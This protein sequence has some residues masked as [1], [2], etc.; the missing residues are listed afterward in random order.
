M[1]Y[2]IFCVKYYC[3]IMHNCDQFD[4]WYDVN[5]MYVYYIIYVYMS[6]KYENDFFCYRLLSDLMDHY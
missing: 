2:I 4:V 3:A 6:L 1:Q 5:M